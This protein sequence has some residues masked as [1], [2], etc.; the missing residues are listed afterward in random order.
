MAGGCRPVLTDWTP[1]G[2]VRRSRAGVCWRDELLPTSGVLQKVPDGRARRPRHDSTSR[3]PDA[4][5]FLRPTAAPL[6]CAAALP[7]G[8]R[9][10]CR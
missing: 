1:G 5:L 8:A 10:L 2:L 7:A 6:A 9:R 4:L 3:S